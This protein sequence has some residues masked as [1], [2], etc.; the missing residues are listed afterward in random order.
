MRTGEDKIRFEAQCVNKYC[1]WQCV[2]VCVY[3]CVCVCLYVGVL[4]VRYHAGT[5]VRFIEICTVPPLQSTSIPP[6][7]FSSLS[8]TSVRFGSECQI[9]RQLGCGWLKARWDTH[10]RL[11]VTYLMQINIMTFIFI[12]F[13]LYHPITPLFTSLLFLL[14]LCIL[15]PSC[16]PPPHALNPSLPVG[17]SLPYFLSSLPFSSTSSYQRSSC[18]S[19]SYVQRHV[20]PCPFL[21]L[22][23]L[24]HLPVFLI[25]VLDLTKRETKRELNQ[26]WIRI[27][28]INKIT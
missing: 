11:I 4:H 15:P 6:L 14:Y 23:P 18:L 2:C 21:A 26:D 24:L 3:L 22:L 25:P 19:V 12:L 1:R 10:V 28:R 16:H 13:Y 8:F 9:D 7:L 17:P 27:I 20:R 5:N